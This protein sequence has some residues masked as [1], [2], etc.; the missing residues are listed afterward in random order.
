MPSATAA[1]NTQYRIDSATPSVVKPARMSNRVASVIVGIGG[2]ASSRV[3][4]A[5][6]LTSTSVSPRA[7]SESMRGPS[8]RTVALRS[9]PESCISTMLRAESCAVASDTRGAARSRST[10][11]TIESGSETRQSSESTCRPIVQ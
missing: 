2:I 3:S 1:A 4:P 9:P 11:A 5:S 8:A 10:L 7:R 6:A